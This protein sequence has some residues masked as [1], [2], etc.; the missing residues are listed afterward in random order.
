[1][2]PHLLLQRL[3]GQL[4]HT[5][6][7]AHDSRNAGQAQQAVYVTGAALKQGLR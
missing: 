2:H 4:L 5:R 6:V 3:L 1:M 7:V